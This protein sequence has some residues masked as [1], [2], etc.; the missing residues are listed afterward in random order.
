MAFKISLV[1]LMLLASTKVRILARHLLAELTGN[2]AVTPR[3]NLIFVCSRQTVHDPRVIR[4]T[5]HLFDAEFILIFLGIFK[6]DE[7]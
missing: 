1:C 2:R 5:D 7:T 4:T 3:L 6:I